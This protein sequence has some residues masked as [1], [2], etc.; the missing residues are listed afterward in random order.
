MAKENQ[1][2]YPFP[3]DVAQLVQQFLSTGQFADEDDVLR[4]ALTA[5]VHQQE[6]V[7]AVRQG[8]AE[9]EAGLGRP[10]EEF[11]AEF[12]RRNNIPSDE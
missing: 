3:T 6:D 1:M 12:G 8:I 9:Y 7:E 11:D 2:I 10:F 5:L 4:G